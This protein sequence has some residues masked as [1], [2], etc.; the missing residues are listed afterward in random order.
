MQALKIVCNLADVVGDVE[1]LDLGGYGAAPRGR[2]A[3]VREVAMATAV[4]V[5]PEDE[6]RGG[7]SAGER[8]IRHEPLR[9]ARE[10]AESGARGGG[11]G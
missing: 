5:G 2:G 9:S 4:R 10:G 7:G 1:A 6:R 8:R 3:G 11:G